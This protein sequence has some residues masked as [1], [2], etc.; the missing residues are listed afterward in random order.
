MM[1]SIKAERSQ[2]ENSELPPAGLEGK[3]LRILQYKATGAGKE[4]G[5]VTAQARCQALTGCCFLEGLGEH[6]QV[7]PSDIRQKCLAPE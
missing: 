1:R 3:R 2:I 5:I 4:S 6:K 7:L